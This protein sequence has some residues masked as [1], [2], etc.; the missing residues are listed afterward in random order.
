MQCI[1][2]GYPFTYTHNKRGPISWP[3]LG[4]NQGAIDRIRLAAIFMRGLLSAKAR[5][6]VQI[7]A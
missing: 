4:H 6:V 1:F 7:Y 2:I 3:S 5:N